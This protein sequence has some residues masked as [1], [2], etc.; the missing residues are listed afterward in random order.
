MTTASARALLSNLVDYA[1]LF[2]PAGLGMAE[3]VAEHARQRVGPESWML[4]RF[5]VPAARL[6]EFEEAILSGRAPSAGAEKRPGAP[7]TLS[8]LVGPAFTTHADEIVAFN[9]RH[10]DRARVDSVEFRAS[11]RAELHAAL[12][13]VPGGL[14]IF[15]ELPL[16]AGLD[17][18][19]GAVRGRAVNAKVRTGGIEAAVIPQAPPLARFLEA[20]AS[21]NVPFKATAGLH[22]PLRAEHP[23]TYA[24][25]A[26]RGTM[27]GFL[28]LF[29]AAA[30]ARDGMP[31]GELEA[32]LRETRPEEFHLD[33]SGLAW[34]DRSVATDDIALARRDFA[35]SFGSCS[36][37]E[38]VAELK[39]L[40]VIS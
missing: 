18:L 20:C 36:F 38:P 6:D 28:N 14:G 39:A 15:V 23:L 10:G 29:A 37:A 16:D 30:F 22:H 19:L 32:V 13:T 17:E 12:D 7:W 33:D 11:S 1:G 3:A 5:V 26:P 25:D 4:G 8:A 27:H 31:A 9:A 24:P 35:L 40:G 21:A 34:R 2:P